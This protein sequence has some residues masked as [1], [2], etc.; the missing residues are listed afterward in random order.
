M[1]DVG[2]AN[3]VTVAEASG[4]LRVSQACL[5]NWRHRGQGP[6]Y[7]K[8]GDLVKY[9][10]DVLDAF[11]ASS[12]VIPVPREKRVNVHLTVA[13]AV[14]KALHEARLARRDAGKGMSE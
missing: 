1:S 14:G 8:L 4:Y 5:N 10:R 7:V 3:L 11:I 6:A 2:G 12:S 13:L 9:R